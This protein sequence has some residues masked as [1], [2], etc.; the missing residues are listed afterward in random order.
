[1]GQLQLNY[2]SDARRWR[3]IFSFQQ[4]TLSFISI[5]TP[6]FRGSSIFLKKIEIFLAMEKHRGT[7]MGGENISSFSTFYALTFIITHDIILV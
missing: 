6:Y 2:E 3:Q 7:R 5:K 4:T 1:M